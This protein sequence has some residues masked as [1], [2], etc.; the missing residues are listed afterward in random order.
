MNRQRRIT[1]P[2]Y[3]EQRVREQPTPNIDPP[4]VPEREIEFTA[5]DQADED[6]SMAI[7]N[8]DP[9]PIVF[10]NE[11]RP[12]DQPIP[13]ID[14]PNVVH[15]R[16]IEYPANDVADG[17]DPLAIP[18]DYPMPIVD[19]QNRLVMKREIINNVECEAVQELVDC[20]YDKY[21]DDITMLYENKDAFK[22]IVS[23]CEI[24]RN[25]DFS[26]NIPFA[27]YA[28]EEGN[29]K[30]RGYMV[31]VGGVLKEIIIKSEYLRKFKE[32]IGK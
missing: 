26:G 9:I 1:P 8:H 29:E 18:N 28:N 11:H 12:H 24:K 17:D 32:C 23:E 27:E 19:T 2:I 5:I 14:A 6:D 7:E 22:P 21:D 31:N 3:N 20:V 30:D 10:S 13:N 4:N 16:E 15:E 25:D